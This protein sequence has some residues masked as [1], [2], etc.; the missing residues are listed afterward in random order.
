MYKATNKKELD[1]AF[2]VV[3][4]FDANAEYEVDEFIEGKFISLDYL[5]V[6]DKLVFFRATKCCFPLGET[7]N[8][9][10]F[11]ALCF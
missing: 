5:F 1:E 8:G 9:K 4:N 10:P 11:A 2:E 3:L 7:L 6:R